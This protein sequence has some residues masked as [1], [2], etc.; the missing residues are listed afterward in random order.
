MR[1]G[2]QNFGEFEFI[3]FRQVKKIF[4]VTLNRILTHGNDIFVTHAAGIE[5]K[6]ESSIEADIEGHTAYSIADALFRV[7]I[8]LIFRIRGEKLV[9]A[10]KKR[11]FHLLGGI[12][13]LIQRFL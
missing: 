1:N 3:A 9:G 7:I 8:E 5:L 11:S 10:A 12:W 2:T 13:C 4:L 6:C